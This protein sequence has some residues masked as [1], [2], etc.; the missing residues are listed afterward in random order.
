MIDVNKLVQ[1]F[2]FYT[3]RNYSLSY[4]HEQNG[5]YKVSPLVIDKDHLIPFCLTRFRAVSTQE[6]QG[7]KWPITEVNLL[8]VRTNV[9]EN[10]IDHFPFVIAYSGND[11]TRQKEHIVYLGNAVDLGLK[12][13]VYRL[14]IKDNYSHVGY[15][16]NIWTSNDF[17]VSFPQHPIKFEFRM[18]PG[19]DMLD[20]DLWY[21]PYSVNNSTFYYE[22]TLE[23]WTSDHG[24]YSKYSESN[25]EGIYNNTVNGFQVMSK[26]RVCQ[27]MGDADTIDCLQLMQMISLDHEGEVFIT[28]ET[29]QRQQIEIKDLNVEPQKGDY[30]SIMITY[31]V[32]GTEIRSNKRNNINILYYQ[33][34]SATPILESADESLRIGER[35]LELNGMELEI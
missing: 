17:R 6:E 33:D 27:V 25:T 32:I 14:I 12:Q 1:P 30:M 7:E 8:N 16:A 31:K 10:I 3:N 13:E 2:R 5:H 15:S 23:A 34:A 29:G 20:N 18:K 21:Y 35:E 19:H 4:R 9:S 26:L 24:E 11:N 22:M 28:D